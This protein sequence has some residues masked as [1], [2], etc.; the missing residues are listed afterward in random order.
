MLLRRPDIKKE[1]PFSLEQAKV[2]HS[3]DVVIVNKTAAMLL[4]SCARMTITAM[5]WWLLCR[6]GGYDN[7]NVVNVMCL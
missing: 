4:R 6:S 1:A 7:Y 5:V 2:S 3:G